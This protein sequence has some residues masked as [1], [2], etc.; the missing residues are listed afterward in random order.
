M[1]NSSFLLNHSISQDRI[2]SLRQHSQGSIYGR[3]Y[4]YYVLVRMLIVLGGHASVIY[5]NDR[6]ML[7]CLWNV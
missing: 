1:L 7:Y 5:C 4:T 6:L 2:H 3:H